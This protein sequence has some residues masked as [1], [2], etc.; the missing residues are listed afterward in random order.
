MGNKIREIID[1]KALKISRVIEKTGLSKSYFYDVMN[2]VSV[3][4]LAN[5]RK[6]SEVL[7]A[8]LDQLFP[9]EVSKESEV[10]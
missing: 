5:A 3:P 7:K 4:S 6:I 2:G 10:E 8:P 1:E 9:D